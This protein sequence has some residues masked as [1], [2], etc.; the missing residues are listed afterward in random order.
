[1]VVLVVGVVVA[2]LYVYVPDG[3]RPLG[4]DTLAVSAPRRVFLRR[5]SRPRK[6]GE[7]LRSVVF[8]NDTSSW[9]Q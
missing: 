2:H 1:M 7:T 8:K 4:T 9:D 3:Y 5:H 6:N